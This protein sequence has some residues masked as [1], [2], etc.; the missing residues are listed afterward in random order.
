MVKHISRNP[1]NI[2]SIVSDVLYKNQISLHD[3]FFT[4]NE[5]VIILD[6]KDAAKTYE[7]LRAKVI[8]KG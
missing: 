2:L 6:D 8:T 4:P 1:Y 5:I 3:A 7:L